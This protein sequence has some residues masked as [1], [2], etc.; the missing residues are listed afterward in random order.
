M[1]QKDYLLREIEKMGLLIRAI[2]NKL[3]G[4]GEGSA[5]STEVSF[6]EAKTL[7]NEEV[8]FNMDLFLEMNDADAK[9][10]LATFEGL[11]V[12]NKE[13]LAELL[14]I[15]QSNSQKPAVRKGMLE[16]TLQILLLCRETDKTFSMEREAMISKV[17][18]ALADF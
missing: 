11:N 1:E 17:E 3:L 10:Y 5:V 12:N 13:M 18:E 9:G 4:T 16:K 8:N 7:L 2:I 14:F 15:A 6:S